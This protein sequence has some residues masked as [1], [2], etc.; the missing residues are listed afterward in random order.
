M[1]ALHFLNDA[2]KDLVTLID[3][4]L[5]VLGAG[6]IEVVKIFESFVQ[7]HYSIDHQKG[8]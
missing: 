4:V 8:L 1:A 3:S 6:F 5:L 2:H 7:L